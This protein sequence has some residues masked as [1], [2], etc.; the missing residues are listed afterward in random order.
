MANS[1]SPSQV[2]LLRNR[3]KSAGVTRQYTSSTKRYQ[4]VRTGLDSVLMKIDARPATRLDG[5]SS[6]G[7]HMAENHLPTMVMTP[8]K[9]KGT[10]KRLARRPAK[11]EKSVNA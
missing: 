8:R 5:A 3:T 1:N 11:P 7:N 6:I 2:Q 4:I 10:S 9:R